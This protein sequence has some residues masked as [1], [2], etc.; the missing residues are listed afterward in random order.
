MGFKNYRVYCASRLWA[1]IRGSVM[2]LAGGVCQVCHEQ[3]T[4]I[5]HHLDYEP[6]TMAGESFDALMA[7]C[8]PCHNQ[9]HAKPKRGY[10]G[11][12]RAKQV[13]LTRRQRNRRKLWMGVVS[14]FQDAKP[15][16]VKP[17]KPPATP[18]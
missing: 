2:V 16:L 13:R 9:A 7:V 15:R 11:N 10:T 8:E 4:L 3:P 12:H 5:V 17:A 14:R 6:A 1:R 18:A